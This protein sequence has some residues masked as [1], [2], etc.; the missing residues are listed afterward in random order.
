MCFLPSSL[1]NARAPTQG[2]GALRDFLR[3][4]RQH[5]LDR[6]NGICSSALRGAGCTLSPA[7]PSS[8]SEDYLVARYYTMRTVLA[9]QTRY[10][11]TR[12]TVRGRC[13]RGPAEV[14]LSRPQV[15]KP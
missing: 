4:P 9:G 11:G 3:S 13:A 5:Y 14:P 10:V 1:E 2:V 6:V 12:G 8:P 7:Q 15:A